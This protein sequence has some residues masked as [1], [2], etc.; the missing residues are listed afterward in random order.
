M[1]IGGE[2]PEF[3]LYLRG[4]WLWIATLS[5]IITNYIPKSNKRLFYNNY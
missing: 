4:Y 2:K 3:L 5:Y 1:H